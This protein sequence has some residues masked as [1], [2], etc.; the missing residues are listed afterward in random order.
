MGEVLLYQGK[1]D[2]AIAALRKAISLAPDDPKA[3]R[4][5]AKALQAKGLDQEAQEELKKAG[6][7]PN[8]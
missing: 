7:P 1:A 3:H 8:R 6:P 5:L 4:A 2:E